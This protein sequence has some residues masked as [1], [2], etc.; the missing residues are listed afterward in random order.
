MY[1][2]RLK[3]KVPLCGSRTGSRHSCGAFERDYCEYDA[4]CKICD[5][6]EDCATGTALLWNVPSK[7]LKQLP[8][9]LV[10]EREDV[11]EAA[12]ERL[13]RIERLK[14]PCLN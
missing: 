11:R 5:S 4:T 8:E 7:D 9:F 1:L 10:H 12:K 2:S 14:Q 13:D 3:A 6:I